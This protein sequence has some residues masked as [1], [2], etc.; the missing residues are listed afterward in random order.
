V[1]EHHV[2]EEALAYWNGELDE[3]RRAAVATHLDRCATCR[4]EFDAVRLALGALSDWPR[5]A[6][7]DPTLEQRLVASLRKRSPS[8]AAWT[9]R[10]AAVLAFALV[11]GA[12]F[13]AGR[14]TARPTLAPRVTASA[15]T[16]LD[17]YL[18]LL[19]EVDGPTQQSPGRED[20]QAW[21][22][23]LAGQRRLVSAEKLTD[24]PG[25]RVGRDGRADRPTGLPDPSHVTGWFLIRARSYDEAIDWARRGPHLRHGTVLV[26]QVE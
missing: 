4:D 1:T 23:V 3:T 9:R 13:V 11:G 16:T 12:G 15:D 20:Y 24:E 21:A 14:A 7:L 8:A 17:S 2:A 26:R 6:R 18:L 10:V 25:F 22:R 5:D 19:E